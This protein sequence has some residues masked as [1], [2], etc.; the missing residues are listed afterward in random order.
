MSR[1]VSAGLFLCLAAFSQAAKEL[2]SFDVASVKKSPPRANEGFVTVTFDDHGPG[3]I[4]YRNM[5]LLNLLTTAFDLKD[6][7]IHGPDW[8]VSEE[9]DISAKAPDKT[10]YR[11]RMLMLQRL[12]AER[13]H[14]QMAPVHR[15]TGACLSGRPFANE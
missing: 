11:Q 6:Y 8:M 7:Q 2:P 10:P 14:M 12:L 4:N 15:G 1:T 9:Y 3:Q 5:N 13:L